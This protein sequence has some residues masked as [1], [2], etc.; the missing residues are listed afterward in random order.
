M[1]RLHTL[2]LSGLALSVP[3]SAQILTGVGRETNTALNCD[4]A[5]GL[6]GS[7][8]VAYLNGELFVSS[9]GN[10]GGT[11]APHTVGVF[12]PVTGALLR[13][14]QQPASAST[15]AWGFR[16]GTTDGV[17]LI[18]GSEGGLEVVD[19]NG[20]P[21][22]TIVAANGPQTVN[23]PVTTPATNLWRGLAFDRNGNG[24][25]GSLFTGNFGTAIWETDLNGVVLNTFPLPLAPNTWSTYGLELDP[26]GQTIWVNSVPNAGDVM[27]FQI[28]RT[29]QQ[30]IPTGRKFRPLA[31][32]VQGGLCVIP[33]GVDG[34][35][36]GYDLAVLTQ[37]T[38]D[39]VTYHRLD[40]WTN[41]SSA[42]A[43]WSLVTGIDNGARNINNK[44]FSI[45]TNSSIEFEVLAPLGTQS[46]M[47]LEFGSLT[48]RPVGPVFGVF[49]EL[50]EFRLNTLNVNIPLVQI[51]IPLSLQLPPGVG[52]GEM[53]FQA[54][55]PDPLGL[56]NSIAPCALG[57]PLQTSNI[58]KITLTP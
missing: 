26:S 46:V 27:E 35:N 53:H 19:I 31:T 1:N 22:N 15:S 58:C 20:N 41:F 3:V 8:G 18:F 43:E 23:T 4:A 37:G 14:W 32:V 29:N 13:T 49:K 33:G 12:N 16:D 7:L 21:V 2:V 50:W 38:P 47:F 28:D 57:I 11:V 30:L 6:N 9:R 54:V 17:N 39:T 34:R 55:S 52:A 25:N 36:C 10:N 45:A 40:L 51:G 24:G 44:S 48:A 5:L 56:L 42:T